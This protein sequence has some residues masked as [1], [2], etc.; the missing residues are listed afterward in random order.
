MNNTAALLNNTRLKTVLRRSFAAALVATLSA[1]ASFNGIAPKSQVTAPE[2]LG[3]AGTLPYPANDWWS[4]Y[5]DPKLSELI[6]AAVEG[7]PTMRT[8]QAR[9]DKAQAQI[10]VS[11]AARLPQVGLDDSNSRQR[12][13]ENFI[14]PPPFGGNWF[15]MNSLQANASWE[16]DLFG[17]NRAALDAAI[18]QARAAETDRE[19]ARVLLAARVASAYFNL[20]RNL[21]QRKVA[22]S[23]LQEREQMEKLVAQRVAAGL[24]TNVELRQAQ[25]NPPQTR[26][27]IAALD[28]QIAISRHAIAALA[29]KG[30][31]AYNDLA[32][33]I[34]QR[35]ALQLP[36]SLPADLISRRADIVAA[37]WRVDA[38]SHDI[39]A[40][41]AEFYPDVNLTAFIG[42]QSLGFTD[43]INAASRVI[44]VG[45]A[46]HLPIFEGGKLRGNL[47]AKDAD[48]DLAVEDYNG[49]LIDALRD[50]ADQLTSTHSIEVQ[51][52]EQQKALAA[53][54]S[55][56]DLAQQRYRSGLSTY[57]SVLTAELNL[58]QQRRS[59]VDL[60]ARRY[61]Q[62]V[63]LARALG[64]GF[65][66][67]A[68]Q[69]P[70][71][72]AVKTSSAQ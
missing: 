65:H 27:E 16:L 3:A 30:P 41:K 47:R 2:T 48:Y 21:E 70:A 5:N 14:Y 54:T 45:P 44:G 68:S 22:D 12:F 23:T 32:P 62:D 60:K 63:E 51:W 33:T 50:V 55:A 42:F 35:P 46:V 43:W 1:C 72:T 56:Y 71:D 28:E 18:G 6:N 26:Q 38:A 9:L 52:S 10:Q 7:S 11:N 15:W 67:D 59:A 53:A 13:S 29:G 4:A 39:K 34:T 40:A 61:T 58:E 37:R 49:K 64:G 36:V 69:L 57:L 19:A 66:A 25:G 24:D 20:A 8:A 31:D 17:K